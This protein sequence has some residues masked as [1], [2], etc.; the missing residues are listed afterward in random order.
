[1]ATTYL[2]YLI[3]RLR[4]QIGDTDVTAYRYTDEQLELTLVAAVEA[5][6]SWWSFKYL[7]NEDDEVYRNPNVAFE[8]S[9]PPV[10]QR[11]DIRP[12]IL[13]ASAVNKSASLENMAFNLGAWRDAEVSVSNIESGKS[14]DRSL[15]RDLDELRDIL[16]PPQKRL[17]GSAKTHL[18]GYVDNLYED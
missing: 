6:Q 4:L 3:R 15:Q 2:T 13:M 9:E 16:K 5:L 11:S 18:P 14:K 10:I 17:Y 1:M 12:I 7:I 8:Y